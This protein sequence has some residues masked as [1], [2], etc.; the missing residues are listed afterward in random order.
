MLHHR[1][2]CRHILTYA[3]DKRRPRAG[4]PLLT[5]LPQIPSG[6]RYGRLRGD[7][8]PTQ[9]RVRSGQ[10]GSPWTGVLLQ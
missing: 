4:A 9:D 3:R 1:L 6:T 8:T 2:Q 5:S 10:E 7:R